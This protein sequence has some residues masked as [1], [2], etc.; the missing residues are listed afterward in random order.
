MEKT[1]KR[2]RIRQVIAVFIRHGITKGL[3]GLK[4]PV[5]IR[6]AFEELGPTFVKIGQLLSTQSDILPPAFQKEFRKLQDNVAPEKFEDIRKLLEDGFHQPISKTFP[7]FEEKAL[8]GAS[9]AVVYRAILPTGETVAVKIQRPGA[10]EALINDIAV[11]RVLFRFFK[12]RMVSGLMDIQDALD[13][14]EKNSKQ[15][16][17]FLS[18][19][20]NMKHFA[21]NN[22]DVKCI[23]VP[24]VYDAYTT[25]TILTM[26]YVDGIKITDADKLLKEG[27]DLEDIGTKLADNYMKQIFED[28]FFHADPHPGN[29]FVADGRIVYI[30]FGLMG[31]LDK[32]MRR[33]LNNLLRSIG[34]NDVDAMTEAILRIGIPKGPMDVEQFYVDI[35]VFYERYI[36]AS[37]DE[38]NLSQLAKEVFRICQKNGIAIPKE[39][40][41][42]GKGL[43]TIEGVL[44]RLS[45]EINMMSISENFGVRHLFQQES[46][47]R[48]LS[49]MVRNVAQSG[50]LSTKIPTK[51]YRLLEKTQTEGLAVKIKDSQKKQ[52]LSH[53]DRMVNRAILAV[54]IAA[55]LIGSSLVY[56]VGGSLSQHIALGGLIASGLLGVGLFI[57][58]LRSS[59]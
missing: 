51:M 17:N 8:A 30:D 29:I 55:L 32:W 36:A 57:G 47:R 12:I 14:L 43:A 50:M 46:L 20:K 2:E 48:E 58:F 35:S 16:L 56:Q 34:T 54:L 45:P 13:E 10:R 40:I 42:L 44:T 41:M 18:E 59:F 7:H 27:Y 22:R 6:L 3:R 21:E 25:D 39:V 5:N 1:R 9:M 37:F 24:K 4:D 11:L 52:S 49:E 33:K 28:G 19:A 15:E 38:I 31:N 53:I 26:D 23:S